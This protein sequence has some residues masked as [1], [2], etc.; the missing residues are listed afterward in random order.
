MTD[1][2]DPSLLAALAREGLDG[3]EG[4]FAYGGGRDLVKPGLGDRQRTHL[5][6][7][8]GRGRTHDLYLKRYGPESLVARLKRFLKTGRSASPARIECENIRAARAAG[9]PTMQAVSWGEEPGLL[10]RRGYLVVAAVPGDALERAGREFLARADQQGAVEEFTRRLADLVRALHGA[11]LV[12][13]DLYSSHIFLHDAP[14]GPELHL[15]D[16]ARAFR[17]RWRT[18]RW[19]VKD[20]AQLKCSMDGAWVA[21]CWEAFLRRYLGDGAEGELV[22]YNRAVDRKVAAM[23][24]RARRNKGRG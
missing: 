11:G 5:C 20:L 9:V 6:I 23:R 15:I 21:S 13:R 10:P 18:F 19:F 2:V 17:P 12:H 24:S 16:L 7:A 4:A 1:H 22:R 8:D 3:V 14:G